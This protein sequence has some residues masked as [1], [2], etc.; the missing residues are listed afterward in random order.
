MSD[1]W[2]INLVRDSIEEVMLNHQKGDWKNWSQEEQLNHLHLHFS[3][4][5]GLLARILEKWEHSNSNE[6]NEARRLTA[7]QRKKIVADFMIQSFMLA[8]AWGIIDIDDLIHA[9]LQELHGQD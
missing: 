6:K 5:N 1:G 4:T 9:R 2:G 3:K 7:K 8:S